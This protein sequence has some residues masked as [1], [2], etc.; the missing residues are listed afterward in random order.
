[1]AEE[2]QKAEFNFGLIEKMGEYIAK[3]GLFGTKTKD[4]A[5]ALMLIANAEGRHPASAAQDYNIIQGRP[6][7]KADAM[8]ARFQ[9]AGGIVTWPT[10]TDTK[11][12]GI[13]K[14]PQG[15]T[16]QVEWDIERAKKITYYDR[17][18]SKWKSMAE[19]DNWKNYPRAM[20]RARVISEAIRTIYPGVL[21][22]MYTPEEVM[23]FEPE[24]E[25]V[26][27]LPPAQVEDQA[28]PPA[29]KSAP[30]GDVEKGRRMIRQVLKDKYAGVIA[31]GDEVFT[32]WLTKFELP[33]SIDA[34]DYDEARRV[35]KELSSKGN[36][37]DKYLKEVVHQEVMDRPPEERGE[38]DIQM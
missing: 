26:K 30:K 32:G 24:P 1:M 27:A 9:A 33:T 5:I 10:Y 31:E 13:F 36:T 22:G 6:A 18:S 34:L 35:F 14:H 8:L 3:S 25:P 19:K 37:L 12:T 4:Q 7:L 28:P 2:I 15:G 21:G 20:L 29:P 38:A 17:D 16:L 23:D 11:V